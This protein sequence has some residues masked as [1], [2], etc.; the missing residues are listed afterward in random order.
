MMEL[1]DAVVDLTIIA[2]IFIVPTIAYH[3]IFGA[4]ILPRNFLF[5]NIVLV[6][7]YIII[8]FTTFVAEA[9]L[10]YVLFKR[11]DRREHV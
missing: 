10:F 7:V 4:P 11:M 9:W 5:D 3:F 8:G 2:F 1:Q 6:A